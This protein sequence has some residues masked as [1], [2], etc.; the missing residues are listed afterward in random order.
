MAELHIKSL[1]NKKQGWET[2]WEQWEDDIIRNH[3]PSNGWEGV[4][5]FLPHR[6]KRG[7][8][9]RAFKLGVKILHYNENYFD[10]I[11]DTNKA[12]WLGFIYTDGY[13]TTGD[14]WGMELSEIDSQH[15]TNL[16]ALLDSNLKPKFR[17]RK[18]R[19]EGYE[20]KSYKTVN[21]LI[22]NKKMYSDLVKHGVVPNKTK[23]ISF[24]NIKEEF[25]AD[26]IRG[27][28]DGDGCIYTQKSYYD[29]EY[30]AINFMSASEDFVDKI[31]SIIY[32]ETGIEFTKK[33]HS[34]SN[35]WVLQKYAKN[36]VIKFIKYLY[37]N[38]T[39]LNR[40][41]RKYELIQNIL[42]A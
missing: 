40:L 29:Y 21:M 37:K 5:E 30:L 17:T 12:Y 26:F 42:I 27:L 10:E 16:L 9:S 14:R 8:Q 18:S 22:T 2:Q 1:T 35:V 32:D 34:G 24:P 7:I 41:E 28:F 13:V 36:D 6:N 33:Y 39:P 11:D 25:Y 15:I 23:C 31:R 4:I 3:Y 20:E 19:F 38:S